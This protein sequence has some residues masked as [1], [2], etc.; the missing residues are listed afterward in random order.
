MTTTEVP[1]RTQP[2]SITHVRLQSFGLTKLNRK[3]EMCKAEVAPRARFHDS[4][5]S[6]LALG[7]RFPEIGVG[8]QKSRIAI[9]GIG[10]EYPDAAN[11]SNSAKTSS[12]DAEHFGLS[13]TR[14]RTGSCWCWT[15]S[16]RIPSD[17]ST[18]HSN[19]ARPCTLPNGWKSYTPLHGSWLK[20]RR[21]RTVCADP[22]M[23]HP[24]H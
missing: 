17:R 23:P 8:M 19:S 20:H 12:E 1:P 16:T 2:N 22:A 9:V 13:T 11:R 5:C 10:L 24:S 21:D 15:P 4:G 18:R 7:H 6:G 14:T 3:L